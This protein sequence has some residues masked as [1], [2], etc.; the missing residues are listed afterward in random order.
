MKHAVLILAL[1]AA[2]CAAPP[3]PPLDGDADAC[4]AAALQ[5]RIGLGRT[6]LT[7]PLPPGT[8]II[9]PG[10]AVTQDFRPDRL[11]IDVDA[12]G[13]ITRIWCG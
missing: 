4:G 2:G 9:P 13:R 7:D 6:A 11:N 3:P 10:T 8:R 5:D 1:A 12:G